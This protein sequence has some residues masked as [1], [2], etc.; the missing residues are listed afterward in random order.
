[1]Y[2]LLDALLVALVTCDN[3][4]ATLQ[5]ASLVVPDMAEGGGGFTGHPAYLV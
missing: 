4:V 1:M 2:L 3:P 5:A